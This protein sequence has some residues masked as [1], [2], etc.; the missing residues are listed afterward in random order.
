MKELG[1]NLGCPSMAG[2][3]LVDSELSMTGSVQAEAIWGL[4]ESIEV[5]QMS[6]WRWN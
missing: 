5:I 3:A 4:E 1:D 6:G 2:G